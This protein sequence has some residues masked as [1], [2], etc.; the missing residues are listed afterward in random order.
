VAVVERWVIAAVVGVLVAPL[1]RALIFRHSVASGDHWRRLCSSCDRP[2]LALSPL[3]RCLRCRAR[4]GP[5]PFAVEAVSAAVLA[6]L[7]WRLPMSLPLLAFGW[8]AMIGVALAFIDWSVH[9]LPDR[10]TLP[11]FGGAVVLLGL[12]NQPG[13]LGT[14]LLC[15]LG[16]AGCYVMLTLI[17]RG[18]L[19]LGDGKLALSLG[20]ALGWFGGMVT[21]YG[22]AAGFILAGLYAGAML[23][24]G[25]L[26]RK[27][28]LAHGPFMLLGTLTALAFLT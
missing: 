25:R 21:V 22:T 18:G 26:G 1:L 12:D 2:V 9:R 27:D 16:M 8:I 3:G 20:L 6:V 11:A 23:A 15:A 14:A 24:A 19:G 10:L 28:S 5:P 4:L 13:R 7:A 17:S